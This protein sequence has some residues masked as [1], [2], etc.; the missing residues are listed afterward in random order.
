MIEASG[1]WAEWSDFFDSKR[2]KD[3]PRIIEWFIN[4]KVIEHREKH[5][6]TR[7]A[8]FKLITRRIRNEL[9]KIDTTVLEKTELYKKLDDILMSTDS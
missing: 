1:S 2:M 7:H 5:N 3:D 9:R 8:W 6:L 4:R